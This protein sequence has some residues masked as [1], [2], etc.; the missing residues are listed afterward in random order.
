MKSGERGSKGVGGG[1]RG[2]WSASRKWGRRKGPIEM[3]EEDKRYSWRLVGRSQG[4]FR[5]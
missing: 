3:D 5:G 1:G 2:K 4:P